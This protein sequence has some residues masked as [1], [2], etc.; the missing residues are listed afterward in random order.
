M[1][2]SASTATSRQPAANEPALHRLSFAAL[3]TTC[4][5]QYVAPHGMQRSEPFEQAAIQWVMAFEARYSRFRPTSL[6][7]QINAAAG[8]DWIKVDHEMGQLFTLCDAV[9]Q[10]TDGVLDPTILPLMKL[11]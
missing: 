3:G 10:M 2:R 5:I 6:I 8:R 4:E 9:Y 11:W 1:I 7:S